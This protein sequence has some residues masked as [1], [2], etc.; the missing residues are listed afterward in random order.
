VTYGP[1]VAVPARFVNREIVSF[2]E[3][4]IVASA[5]GLC[6]APTTTRLASI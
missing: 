2:V 6:C 1:D 3:P 5:R 4:M